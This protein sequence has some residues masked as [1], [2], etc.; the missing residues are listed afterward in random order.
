MV[1]DTVRESG[2][3]AVAVEE[4]RLIEWQREVAAAEG[5]MICPEAATCVGAL[6]KLTDQGKISPSERVV[7]FNTAAGQ[8]YFGQMTKPL[9]VPSIDLSQPTDWDEFEAKY[10]S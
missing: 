3:E 5:V 1:L 8:K 7:I 10:L 6:Q 9:D 4:S 2:G